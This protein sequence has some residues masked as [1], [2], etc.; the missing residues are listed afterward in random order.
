MSRLRRGVHENPILQ[1]VFNK[2]G[3]EG[4]RFEVVDSCDGTRDTL[5]SREQ[6]YIDT[7]NPCMNIATQAGCPSSGPLTEEQRAKI[8]AAL[9]GIK[10]SDAFREAQRQR[11][12]GNSPSKETRAKQAAKKKGTTFKDRAL[13]PPFTAAHRANLTDARYAAVQRA[14]STGYRGVRKNRKGFSGRLCHKRV[15]RETGTFPTASLA[16]A[17]RLVYLAAIPAEGL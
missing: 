2:Y 11:M 5:L 13:P 7:L 17:M 10:R 12:L 1:N 6:H 3:Q 9:K 14:N 16:Y 15:L 4:L 8:A